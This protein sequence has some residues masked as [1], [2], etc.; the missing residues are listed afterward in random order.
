MPPEISGEL[1]LSDSRWKVIAE[2]QYPWERDA[3][4]FVRERLPDHDPYLAWSNFELIGQDGSIN[5]I[6][7]LVLAPHGL[8]LIEIKSGPGVVS[9]DAGTWTWENEGRRFTADNPLL[10]ANRKAQRLASLLRTRRA[11][12]QSRPPF[13][14]AAVFLSHPSVKLQLD[15]VARRGVYLRDVPAQEGRPGRRGIAAMLTQP[16]SPGASQG[17]SRIDRPVARALAQAMEQAGIR[18]TQR[19]RKVGDFVLGKLAFEGP[20]YQDWE[21][22][23]VALQNVHRRVR[24][25][26][27]AA[28]TSTLSRRTLER[29]AQR[30]Y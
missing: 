1:P 22:T 21:A 29:A 9:G 16:P 23:H 18:P 11:F 6:D 12:N 15:D 7:L 19:S 27:V 20:G 25:Y 14:E 28:G 10:L 2:S 17:R 30:E 26:T 3:L 24:I 5:E 13:V 8:F 4:A